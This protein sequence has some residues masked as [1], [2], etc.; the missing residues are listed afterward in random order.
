M[1][2]GWW[3]GGVGWGGSGVCG[4]SGVEDGGGGVG[5]GKVEE[6]GRAVGGGGSGERG[7]G[8]ARSRVEGCQAAPRRGVERAGNTKNMTV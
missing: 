7:R 2:C 8:G 4:V 3:R 6:V 1:R 5:G